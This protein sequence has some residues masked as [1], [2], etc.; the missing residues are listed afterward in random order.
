[1]AEPTTNS[2][3]KILIAED[4]A[5]VALDLQGMVM[6]LGYDVVSIVDNGPSAVAAAVQFKPDIIIIDM[7]LSGSMDGVQT[8]REI[9]RNEEVPVIFCVASP[10]L[11]VLV[12]AKEV[13]FSSYLLKPIN[14]DTLSTTLDTVLYKFKLEKRVQKAEERYRLLAD[15]CGIIKQLFDGNAAC[16]WLWAPDSGVSIPVFQDPRSIEAASPAVASRPFAELNS[17]EAVT[18]LNKALGTFFGEDSSVPSSGSDSI[19]SAC[20]DLSHSDGTTRLYSLIGLRKA[21]E[22]GAHGM[23]IPLERLSQ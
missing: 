10:D 18:A 1:M 14:P 7:M 5:I 4:D 3:A 8:A 16:E 9:H 12:R 6:R 2:R 11:S 21:G 22:K 13:S 19:I 15:E 17:A 20:I 23:M